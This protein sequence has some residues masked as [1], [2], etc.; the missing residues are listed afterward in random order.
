M[1]PILHGQEEMDLEEI[2]DRKMEEHCDLA[3]ELAAD[4]NN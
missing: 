1:I 2:D 3:A 4:D